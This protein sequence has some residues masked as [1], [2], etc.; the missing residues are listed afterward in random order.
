MTLKTSQKK[1]PL[2]HSLLSL[3]ALLAVLL[4]LPRMVEQSKQFLEPMFA[5]Q[6]HK[7]VSLVFKPGYKFQINGALM[8]V[9]GTKSCHKD[10]TPRECILIEPETQFIDVL[11]G[12]ADGYKREVWVV[13]RNDNIAR[14]RRADGQ[15]VLPGSL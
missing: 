13:E 10:N 8:P 15:Y 14:L 1:T 7:P 3:L 9:F 2:W 5:N 12:Y 4:A 11:V 6:N